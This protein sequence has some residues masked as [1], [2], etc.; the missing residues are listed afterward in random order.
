MN[1]IEWYIEKSMTSKFN[2][3]EKIVTTSNDTSVSKS[4]SI[5]R[6]YT[7]IATV[8]M[9]QDLRAKGAPNIRK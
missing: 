3:C 2:L 6:G 9:L 8:A 4:T 1:V 7:A 5:K